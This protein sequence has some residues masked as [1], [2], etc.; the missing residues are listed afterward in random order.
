MSS[1]FSFSLLDE[2]VESS[3]SLHFSRMEQHHR[4]EDKST[5][6]RGMV[7]DGRDRGEEH[8]LKRSVVEDRDIE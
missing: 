1:C 5:L 6:D 8:L 4:E 3:G 7:V 2:V